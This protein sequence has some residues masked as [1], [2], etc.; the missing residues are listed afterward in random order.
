MKKNQLRKLAMALVVVMFGLQAFAQGRIDLAPKGSTKPVAQNVSMNGFTAS[1]SYSSIETEQVSTEKGDFSI[2]SMGNTLP[3]GNIGEPQVLV[4]RELIAVPFG[5]TP[6]VEVKSYTVQEFN[7]ADYGISRLYPHQAP[8]SKSQKDVKFEYNEKA[9]QV[10]GFDN[11]PIAEVNVMGTMRGIQVGALQLN[12]VRYDASQNVLRVYNDIDVEVRFENADMELT[13]RTLVNTYSPYFRPVYSMLFNEK[14]I[15][16]IYD[17]HPDLWAVPVKILVVANRMF[18]SA[19]QP[20]IQ[21]KTEKGFY[22]DVNYTDQI[23][24]TANAIKTFI[25]NKYN[26]GVAAGQAPTFLIIFGDNGQ[27]PASQTGSASHCVT[28]LYYYTTD[29][30]VFGDMYHSRFTCETVAEL[31]AVLN[32]SLMYEQY[33]MPDP[34]Y[35]SNTLLIAGWDSYWTAYDGAPSIQYAMEY[36]YNTAH[37]F[38]NVYNWLG[39][40]YTGCYAPLNTGV[41]FVN[42]TAHGSNTSWADPSFTNSDVNALTN[43]NK[44]FWAM[45][46][47]C[48]AAD[49]GISGKSLGETFIIAPNKGAF[50]YVG[51]CPSTYWY[52]DYYFTVGATNVF[53]QMPT[54]DQ[55]STGIYDTQFQ[56]DFNSLSAVPFVGNVAVAYAHA[57]GYEGSVTDTYYWESYHVLGDG[58]IC[59]Y[60]VNPTANNVSHMPTLPI[61]MNYYTVTA[62]PGSYV[63]ISK[64]GVLYGAG[65]IGPTGSADIP[66]TPITSGG[67]A[68]IVVTHPQRQPYV[69]TVPA[70]ALTGPYVVVDSYDPHNVPCNEAQQMTVTFKNVGANATTGT[71]NVTLSS[72]DPAITITDATGSFG[73]LAADATT[74]LTNEFAFTVAAGI[75]DNTNVQ[76]NYAATCGSE[77]WEGVMNITVGAPI[78]EYVQMAY[79]GGFTPGDTQTVTAVFHNNGHY[80]ATNAVVTASTTSTYAT[81]VNPSV[82]VGTI[83]VGEDGE[84][85]FQI[86][87]DEAC[88]ESTAIVINFA[89]TADNGV[90]ASGEGIVSNTCHVIF[91]LHDSYGD[92]WNGCALTVSF[93]DGTP[94]QSLTISNGHEAEYNLEISIGTV[95]T[96]TFVAGSYVNETSFEI[97]YEDGDVIY[98]SSGTPSAGQVC[99][100]AVNCSNITYEISATLNPEN[101]G[102]VTGAGTYHEGSTCTLQAIPNSEYSFI[103]WT[104][105][106]VEVSTNAIYSFFVTEDA[107]FVANFGPFEGVV[108]G[109]GTATDDYLPSYSWYKYALSEQIYTSEEIGMSGDITSIAFYNGGAEKTRTFDIYMVNT[110]KTSFASTSDWIA[111]TPDNLVFS[112]TVTM[113]ADAWTTMYLTTPFEYDET[114]N[115]AVIIDDNSGNYTSSP[116]MSCRVF[117]TGST[118]AIV[119][120][121]DNTDF[122]PMNPVASSNAYA[123]DVKNQVR[124]EI[125]AS[126]HTPSNL[127]VSPTGWATWSG[128]GMALPTVTSPSMGGGFEEGFENGIPSDWAVIDADGDGYNWQRSSVMMAGYSITP[129]TGEDMV[130]SQSYDGTNQMA[131]TPDNYLVTPMTLV[132]AGNQFSFWACAQDASYAAEHFGV[133]VST[134]SQTDPSAFTTIQEWTLTAKDSHNTNGITRSGNRTTG[135][136]Y[137][138]NVDLSAY[139]GQMVYIAI[140]H[141][142]CTDMF[143]INIDDVTFGSAKN[144]RGF[145]KNHL[146]LAD[147]NDNTLLTMETTNKYAQIPF[148]NLTNGTTYKFKVAAEY[149][150]GMSDYVETEWVYNTCDNFAGAENFIAMQ[151][152]GGNMSTWDYPANA[153]GEVLFYIDGE[154]LGKLAGGMYYDAGVTDV[155]EYAIRVIHANNAMA[156]GQIAEFAVAYHITVAANPAEGGVVTGNGYF[157]EGTTATIN[158]IPNEHYNFLNWT[159]GNEVVSTDPGYSFTVTE[160]AD[161]IANFEYVAPATFEVVVSADP[162]NLGT[163]TGGGT[164][165]DGDQCTIIATPGPDAHFDNWTENGVVVSSNPQYTFTVTENREF[166]AHFHSTV[167]VDEN[168]EAFVIYPNPASDK[169]YIEGTG[170]EFVEIYNAMGQKLLTAKGEGKTEIDVTSLE[171]G[172]YF[173]KVIGNETRTQ[174]IIVK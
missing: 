40:P 114:M 154:L 167:G 59:Y 6:V 161:F 67:N 128:G 47:C 61:G 28:D 30:D 13:E 160:D 158:A 129:H 9:Y 83:G 38:N 82:N 1:F 15:R 76:I 8:V 97:S 124:L 134:T 107:D 84:A 168:S 95:V 78:I 132:Y 42:Y 98:A 139:A 156:C 108:I 103:N 18:E 89:L 99:Q 5:A 101:A 37:G 93:S 148:A 2:L 71:T 7:L 66:I 80:Q 54:F 24:S 52:E 55:T 91:S 104:K 88:P 106:G 110:E 11:R 81:I 130:S 116:H 137:E 153:T 87:I 27:V 45:G 70:A 105:D 74:T 69:A 65:E 141:F 39:Q 121:N 135:S 53:G 31:E 20:W 155:H 56:D 102:T 159:K 60:H 147:T 150:D 172:V 50:A 73:P 173:I 166:V 25:H 171:K 138:Y 36:Y 163:V 10:K 143:Y 145:I 46:N 4:G 157:A 49:W 12:N 136:W 142:N 125:S 63:G 17:E 62:A 165:T 75:P 34:S 140:R 23:G 174:K 146:I 162:E 131:L 41:G 44:Y 94:E 96:V 115:L 92:G 29:N 123:K 119:T 151:T 3:A 21:W 57:N 120:Y 90:T 122:D 86:A 100:F 164:Y 26:E 77:T 126:V 133:A 118:Q 51:S 169:I 72:T 14:A 16:D 19:M 48:Q 35:L 127:A 170:F 117:S 109:D 113:T 112:G 85:A 144:D 32:K 58:S 43:T 68:K 149:T 64:D 79:S 152:E 33:T 111:A 22:L